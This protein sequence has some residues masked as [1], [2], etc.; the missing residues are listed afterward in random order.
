MPAGKSLPKRTP[1]RVVFGD[2]LNM[3]S[4]EKVAATT[5]KDNLYRNITADVK[6]VIETLKKE[7]GVSQ[8]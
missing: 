6:T 7:S 3:R 2:M 5:T 8:R 4:Y 1:I